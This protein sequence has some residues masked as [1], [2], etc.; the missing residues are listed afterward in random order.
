MV[1]F[2][3]SKDN[4]YPSVVIAVDDIRDAMKK[5]EAAGGT[6]I[7]G[8]FKAGEPD[9][10]RELVSILPSKIQKATG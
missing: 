2:S 7:G 6:I 5:V 3:K 9:D 10:I 1:A 8:G 4:Q